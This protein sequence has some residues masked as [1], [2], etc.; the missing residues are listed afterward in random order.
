MKISVG[1]GIDLFVTYV[2]R[3]K[4]RK[5]EK[6][7]VYGNKKNWEKKNGL[8]SPFPWFRRW[9]WIEGLTMNYLAFVL[10]HMTL[11][12][13]IYLLWCSTRFVRYFVITYPLFLLKQW[14]FSPL[15]PRKTFLILKMGSPW[16]VEINFESKHMVLVHLCMK[17]ISFMRF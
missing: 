16:S 11:E 1:E 7:V 15:Q 17:L 13:K 12:R 3:E 9:F 5:K 4:M 8:M 2:C 10:Y 6:I 14:V